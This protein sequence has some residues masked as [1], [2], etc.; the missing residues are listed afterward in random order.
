MK[1]EAK[2]NLNCALYLITPPSIV[3][4]KFKIELIEALKPG[5]V[6]TLQLRLKNFRDQEIVDIGKFL[7]PICHKFN[8]H[9]LI[10]DRP[11]LANKIGADGVHLGEDDCSIELSRKI[12]GNSAIIGSS[13]Y[14]SKHRAMQ[15]AEKGAD[16]VAFGAFF[17]TQTKIPKY[18]AK[19]DLISDWSTISKVPCVAIGGINPENCQGIIDAGADHIAVINSVWNNKNG[20]YVAVKSFEKIINK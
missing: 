11:D 19:P 12:L 15:A 10:N 7:I 3:P 4:E 20:P 17:E 2:D 8:V 9:F 1:I 18:K 14:N 5:I 6:K 16:Y 13:C